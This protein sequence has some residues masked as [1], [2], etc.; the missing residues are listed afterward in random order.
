[1]V[2]IEWPPEDEM[3]EGFREFVL[4]CMQIEPQDRPTAVQLLGHEYMRTGSTETSVELGT[5]GNGPREFPLADSVPD[6]VG[7]RSVG[8]PNQGNWLPTVATE[9]PRGLLPVPPECLDLLLY[10]AN[11]TDGLPG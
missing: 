11:R 4:E 1:M 3:P 8:A 7:E 2:E 10:G 9:R 6:R 5:T